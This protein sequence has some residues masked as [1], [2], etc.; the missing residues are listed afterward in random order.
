MA[1]TSGFIASTGVLTTSG[2]DLANTITTSRNAAGTILINGG[3]VPI[4]G[5]TPTVANTVVVGVLGNG[6]DDTIALDETNGALPRANLFGGLGNER[7]IGGAGNDQLFGE[8]GNDTLFGVVGA[9]ILNGSNGDDTLTGGD[10]D[11]QL[12]GE[13]GNDRMIWNPGDDSDLLEGGADN[14]TAEVNGGS[15]A[16]TFTATANGTRVR[17]DRLDPTPPSTLDIGTTENLVLNMNGGNDSF[18]ATGNLA[19]L[20]KLTID[21]GAGDDTIL[22]G[23]G[24]DLLSG[25]DGNDFID[26]QQGNDVTQLGAGDDVFQWDPGDGSD[27]VEGQDGFDILLFNGAAANE[28]FDISANAERLRF[29]RDVGNIT[30]NLDNVEEIDLNALGGTDTITVADLSGTDVTAVAISLAGTL[31]GSTGDNAFDQTI[32]NGSAGADEIEVRGQSGALAL[33]GLPASVTINQSEATDAL[34]V[35]GGAGDDV[36]EAITLAAGNTTLTLDG[37]AGN[38]TLLGS[39]G[40][41]TLLGGDGNDR[42][43]VDNAGDAVIESANAGIDTVFSSIH[44]RLSENVEGLDLQGDDDLQAYGNS[45]NNM[46]DG[47]VGNNILDGD[48]GADTMSGGFGNDVYFVDNAGDLALED[49]NDGNDA[50]FSTAHLRLSANVETLVLQGAAD[51]QGYGNGLSNTLH[52]NAGSNI[53]DGDAGVDAML[54]GAGNDIYF[55]DNAGDGV[56]ENANEGNDV[57]FSTAHLRLSANVETLVLQ[58]TADLQGFGNGLSNTLH[59]NAGNNLLDGDAGADAMFGGAGNDIY[60]VDNAGDAVIESAGQ[61]NDAVFSTAHL[62]LSEN[63]ETLVLQGTADLQGYGNG[64]A[65]ALH[66]NSGSNLLDGRGGADTM[67]GGAGNDVYFVDDAGDVVIENVGGG[68]DTVFATV[69]HTLA[70]NVQNLVLQGAGNLLGTGNALNNTIHG[71]S[72]DNTLAGAAGP[73]QLFG[74]QGNDALIGGAGVDNLFGGIGQDAFFFTGTNLDN[75]DTGRGANRDVIHDF[76]GDLLHLVQID[77]NL[78]VATDQAFSFI[79]T[80]AFTAAGQVRFF[81][82]GAGNTIV[83]GNMDN[84]LGADFQIELRSF[85]GQL[86]TSDFL[87]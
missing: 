32:V 77:A 51:L 20:I 49:A 48:A 15:G 69:N 47:N 11:D 7:I 24:N 21:G 67:A 38:D 1:I 65:N 60:F 43:L 75:L 2:D 44:L 27:V 35:K 39:Q 9:D 86:Q 59:G 33:I 46:L 81:A 55:V 14:D 87:L 78:N 12:L 18:N 28:T 50:V 34:V 45:L 42:Y 74:A 53:L 10:G 82:D 57:V 16:E 30:M 52:G 8:A 72:G 76:S 79:G 17:F 85:T 5:G 26:G 66:G 6:G 13:A 54:G 62:Q 25:G 64:Q 3:A 29:F 31:G 84:I 61:G 19:A 73:D 80:N 83:E 22:G 71:N 70:A 40:A 63:V 37:G 68:T 58:G 41:D 23:N 36:I 56:I 4:V